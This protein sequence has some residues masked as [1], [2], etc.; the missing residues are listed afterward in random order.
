LAA[1]HCVGTNQHVFS[2]P[3]PKGHLRYCHHFA[4]VQV[5][6]IILVNECLHFNL[7]L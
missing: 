7:L 2:S 1:K 6:H 4:S 5:V 3:D